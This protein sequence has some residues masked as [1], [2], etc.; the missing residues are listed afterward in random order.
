MY[1]LEKGTPIAQIIPFK[2]EDWESIQGKYEEGHREK[3]LYTLLSKIIRSYKNQYWVKK[4][5]S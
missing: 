1:I 4:T 5:Y 2:R 3:G